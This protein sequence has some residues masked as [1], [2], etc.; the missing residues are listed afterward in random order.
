MEKQGWAKES[1]KVIG[2]CGAF[3]HT[4]PCHFEFLFKGITNQRETTV[5]WHRRTGKPLC[6]AIV[7]TDSRTK[8]TVAHYEH[9]LADTGLEVVTGQFKKGEEGINALREM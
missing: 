2:L 5:A 3:F 4:C 8:N 7:W 6:K 9:V 1:I